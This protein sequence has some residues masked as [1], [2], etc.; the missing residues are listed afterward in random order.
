MVSLSGDPIRT[1]SLSSPYKLLHRVSFRGLA[2]P[3]LMVE[4]CQIFPT[5]YTGKPVNVPSSLLSLLSC[6]FIAIAAHTTSF[7][8]TVTVEVPSTVPGPTLVSISFQANYCRSTP[9]EL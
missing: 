3:V 7:A 6:A 8:T 5:E 9:L 4:H 1:S 2:E